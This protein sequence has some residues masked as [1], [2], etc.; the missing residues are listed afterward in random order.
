M[1]LPRALKTRAKFLVSR[2][3]HATGNTKLGLSRLPK[4]HWMRK[5]A[6][7]EAKKMKTNNF[8]QY[9]RGSGLPLN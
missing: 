6:A 2:A 3:R 4:G 8:G 9:R 7:K 5:D 1:P